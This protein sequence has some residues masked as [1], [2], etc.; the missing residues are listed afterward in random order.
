MTVRA[1][2]LVAAG[3]GAV[4]IWSGLRGKSWSTVLRDIISGH[5]PSIALTAYPIAPGTAASGD[6]TPGTGGGTITTVSSSA[7]ASTALANQNYHYVF[8][9]APVTGNVDCSSW[10]NEIIGG[11]LGLAIPMYKAGA[12]HGQAHGPATVQWL[13]TPLCKTVPFAQ[14]APGDLAVWQTHMGI[15]IGKNRMI[16][17]QDPALGIGEANIKGAIPGEIVF[18]RRLKAGM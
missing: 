9:A 2:Y 16:S 6:G 17:A 1:G 13:V 14:M 7:I 15:V 10:A 11:K 18:I 5:P 8:G 3:G 12:Y 4:L